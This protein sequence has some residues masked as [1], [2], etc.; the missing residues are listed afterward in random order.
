MIKLVLVRHGQS[1]WNEENRFTG[2]HDVDL[3][4][5]GRNEAVKAG[6]F[7]IYPVSSVDQGIEILT[8]VPAGEPDAD[9]SFP[10]DTVNGRVERRLAELAEAARAFSNPPEPAPALTE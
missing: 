8:G 10:E 5:R 1:T 9:G 6:R 2:W 4:E 7:H 3:T